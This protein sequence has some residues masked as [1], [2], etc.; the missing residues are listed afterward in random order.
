MNKKAVFAYVILFVFVVIGSYYVYNTNYGDRNATQATTSLYPGTTAANGT[1]G[2]NQSG[3]NT[4][5]STI[6]NQ[7]GSGTQCT[8]GPEYSCLGMSLSG[9]TGLLS[10]T[11]TQGTGITWGAA[12]IFFL[13][14]SEIPNV[15][16]YGTYSASGASLS[17]VA[18]GVAATARISVI[19]AN[20]VAGT[21]IQGQVWASYSPY[22][23][24][25]VYYGRIANVSAS[26]T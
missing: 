26:A 10:M 18:P 20:S 23:N 19:A 5:A 6:M 17:G 21:A 13:N 9:S 2:A 14:E 3:A 16:G 4:T 1:R 24:S 15:G 8:A 25:T 22:G 7:S 11:F 12:R